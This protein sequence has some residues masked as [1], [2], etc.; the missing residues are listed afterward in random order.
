MFSYRH[1]FHAGNHAD[2]LKHSVLI[3]ILQ[4]LLQKDTALTVFDTHAG[5][6][7]YRLD[8]D[9]AETSGEAANGFL[10]LVK[11]LETTSGS[12]ELT[13]TP[14]KPA[15]AGKTKVLTKPTLNDLA[16]ALK[17]YLEMV[18]SCMLKGA[19][20]FI[21]ARL[22][23]FSACWVI[24]TNSNC[25]RFTPPTSKPYPPTSPSLRRGAK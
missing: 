21:Q 1:A 3:A 7:L 18:A 6:G 11:A 10:R 8:G 16:P 25:S 24:A 5:A 2:V 17:E 15:T 20:R 4:H 23:L 12:T 14:N 19:T 13:A 9:Y 22:L